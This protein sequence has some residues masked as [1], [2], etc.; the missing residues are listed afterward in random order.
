[1]S[2]LIIPKND[3]TATVPSIINTI[4]IPPPLGL[5]ISCELRSF[6][7]SSNLFFIEKRLTKSVIRLEIIVRTIDI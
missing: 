5:G 6:G 4:D 1:M 7:I 3:N 2:G